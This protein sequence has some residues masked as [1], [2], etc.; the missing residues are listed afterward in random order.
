MDNVSAAKSEAY[1]STVNK[2]S[3]A[4]EKDPLDAEL[5]TLSTEDRKKVEERVK[6]LQNAGTAAGAK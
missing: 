6:A 1:R 3:A 5:Q 4:M 2:A